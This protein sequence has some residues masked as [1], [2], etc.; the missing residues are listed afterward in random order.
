VTPEHADSG[1]ITILSTFMYP[2]L[3]V[4]INGEYRPIK[5]VKNAMVVNLGKTLMQISDN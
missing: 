5:P 2:G 4:E 3:E 1:F